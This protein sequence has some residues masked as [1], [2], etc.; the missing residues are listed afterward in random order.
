VGYRVTIC[1][2][3]CEKDTEKVTRVIHDKDHVDLN[4]KESVINDSN[5]NQIKLTLQNLTD[6]GQWIFATWAEWSYK[7]WS[8]WTIQRRIGFDDLD[9][10]K[11]SDHR[12]RMSDNET[13]IATGKGQEKLEEN[14]TFI[15]GSEKNHRP[16]KK[17]KDS[18][19]CDDGEYSSSEEEMDKKNVTQ[20]EGKLKRHFEK[21]SSN[22]SRKGLLPEEQQATE[23]NNMKNLK[24]KSNSHKINGTKWKEDLFANQSRHAANETKD[25][26]NTTEIGDKDNL[27]TQTSYATTSPKLSTRKE[28]RDRHSAAG[29]VT[30]AKKMTVPAN[31][32]AAHKNDNSKQSKKAP[33]S[34]QETSA[35]E[36]KNRQEKKEHHELN[37][38][39]KSENAQSQIPSK[40][41]TSRGQIGHDQHPAP[42]KHRELQV[43]DNSTPPM[44]CF[45]ADTKVYTQNGEKTMKDVSVGDFVLVPISKNQLRYERVEMFYHRE[46]ETRAKFVVLETES[47]RKLSLTELHLLPLGDCKQM[48]ESISDTADIVDDIVDQWLRKSKF[49]Y[50]ARTG[51]CVFTISSNH[52]LQVDRI[53][54]IGRQYL[55]GIYSPMTVEGSILADGVLASCFSQVESHFSQKLVYDFLIFLYRIFGRFIQ[56]MDEPIQHLPTFID[57]IYHLGCSCQQGKPGPPGIPGNP[58]RDGIDG[59]P[60]LPGKDGRPGLHMIPPKGGENTCQKCPTAPPGPPGLH[61]QRGPRGPRGNPGVPGDDGPLG[62]KGPPGPT[63]VRGPPGPYGPKGPPGDSG[64]ILNGAHAG[65]S[66]PPGPIGPRGRIGS[67]GRDGSTGAAGMVGMRGEQGERG[68]NGVPGLRGPPGPPGPQGYKGNCD[69]C[70]PPKELSQSENPAEYY[71]MSSKIAQGLKPD[72]EEITEYEGIDIPRYYSNEPIKGTGN[73]PIGYDISNGNERVNKRKQNDNGDEES[74][75]R[76]K[77]KLHDPYDTKRIEK[78]ELIKAYDLKHHRPLPISPA[79]RKNGYYP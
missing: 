78:Y 74:I 45:S 68:E 34:I 47:G 14:K 64:R 58:G 22:I 54:K 30:D 70:S 24:S 75:D 21:S 38:K 25:N 55:K 67:P 57:S 3:Q 2:V 60:G 35:K 79:I 56:S 39:S 77:S 76:E 8:E 5:L 19:D 28:D 26:S 32:T 11:G 69:H 49:A 37:D 73:N 4:K 9:R 66:G 53:V 46:P 31:Q 1:S 44:N 72:E 59:P 10:T 48:H 61:G 71:D 7:H 36:Q 16:S 62:R 20:K 17:E 33:D 29:N 63:G 18:N 52:Q 13:K 15:H 40:G 27:I 43:D 65:P 23:L 41:S 6:D 51:D 12:Y 50:K 42:K